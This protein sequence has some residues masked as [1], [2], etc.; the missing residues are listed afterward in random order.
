MYR[1]VRIPVKFL[2]I[3]LWHRLEIEHES[4]ADGLKRVA[5]FCMTYKEPFFKLHKEANNA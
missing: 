1:F 5:D 2:G 4:Y 3:T